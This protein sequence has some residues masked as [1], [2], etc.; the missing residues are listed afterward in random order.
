M[1]HDNQ[2]DACHGCGRHAV[3]MGIHHRDGN[4]WLCKE[5]VEIVEYVRSA[6]RLDAYEL[7]ARAGG[8]DAA[9]KYLQELG[10]T[11]LAEF[12]EEEAAMLCGRIWKGCADELRRLIRDGSAP[13]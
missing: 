10:K 2:P 9:G 13:F 12:E 6:K 7:K 11:D 1:T 3:G 8:V 5:C 4:R